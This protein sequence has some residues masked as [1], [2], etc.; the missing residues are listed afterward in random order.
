M[1]R[2]ARPDGG[3]GWW[4]RRQPSSAMGRT[5]GRYAIYPGHGL[6]RAVWPQVGQ[7]ARVPRARADDAPG[8]GGRR[9]GLV[10]Q[11]P[12]ESGDVAVGFD[13]VAAAARGD[14]VVPGVLAA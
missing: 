4:V 3:A 5:A 9:G 10:A 1:R 8:E 11:A 14:H 6:L 2:Q 13:V 7:P 12:A